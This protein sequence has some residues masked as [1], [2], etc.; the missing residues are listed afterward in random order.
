MRFRVKIEVASSKGKKLEHKVL[1]LQTKHK[2]H[3]DVSK[4]EM[5]LQFFTKKDVKE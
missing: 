1:N 3:Q 4:T 2:L 5:K